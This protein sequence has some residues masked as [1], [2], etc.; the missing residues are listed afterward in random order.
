LV[1]SVFLPAT[2][3]ADLVGD[4]GVLLAQLEQQLQMVSHAISTV[5]NL[6]QTVTHL[7]NVVDQGKIML[8][9]AGHGGLAGL[10]DSAQGFIGIARGVTGSLR[11]IDTDTRWWQSNVAKLG[12]DS[13]LTSEDRLAV[14]VAIR[15]MDTERIKNAQRMNDATNQLNKDS[16]EAFASVGE[17]VRESE[18]GQGVVSQMQALNRINAQNVRVG[19]NQQ[20]MTASLVQSNN[21]EL[22]RM[23]AERELTRKML[24]ESASGFGTIT[25]SEP[26]ALPYEIEQ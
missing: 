19:L 6:V 22:A 17:A 11:R 21:D 5:Q 10:L 4:V 8:K 3:S 12:G 9:R 18:A 7:K 20:A 2:A 14:A 26:A 23:A 25:P 16:S 1:A 15:E 13:A 24:E